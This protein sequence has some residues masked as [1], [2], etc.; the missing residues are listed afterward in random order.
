[1]SVSG[2]KAKA[3]TFHRRF[4]RP[5]SLPLCCLCAVFSATLKNF[6]FLLLM[7]ARVTSIDVLVGRRLGPFKRLAA[8]ALRHSSGIN[9][10]DANDR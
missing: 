4:P 6:F 2:T 10:Q 3:A 5:N 7:A 1:M 8:A 9:G